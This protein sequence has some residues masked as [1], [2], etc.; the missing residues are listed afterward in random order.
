MPHW[1]ETQTWTNTTTGY[2]LACDTRYGK[3][4]MVV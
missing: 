4:R 1:T 2:V 3:D